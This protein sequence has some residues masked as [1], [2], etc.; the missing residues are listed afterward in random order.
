MNNKTVLA[1]L[2]LCSCGGAH[3]L[4][5]T[6]SIVTGL[7]KVALSGENAPGAGRTFNRNFGSPVINNLG[8]TAFA[9]ALNCCSISGG[10]WS[11][12]TGSLQNVGLTGSPAQPG[13]SQI[14]SAIGNVQLDDLGRTTVVA[15]IT[16]VP[17]EFRGAFTATDST[18]VTKIAASG[19]PI[20]GSNPSLNFVGVGG[21]VGSS[22]VI[23]GTAAKPNSSVT[24]LLWVS[25]GN[26]PAHKLLQS[27]D[28]VPFAG[29]NTVFGSQV[30]NTFFTPDIN[31]VGQLGLRASFVTSSSD[32]NYNYHLILADT[33]GN[34]ESVLD[35]GDAAPGFAAGVKFGAISDPTINNLGDFAYGGVIGPFGVGSREGVWISKHGAVPELIALQN[36]QPAA[37]PSL[38]LTKTFFDDTGDNFVRISDKRDVAFIGE[39]NGPGLFNAESVWIGS[40]ASNVHPLL[41]EGSA[42]PERPSVAFRSM[43]STTGDLIS[44]LTMNKNSQVAFLAGISGVGPDLR[45]GLFA[46]DAAGVLHP[47]VLYGDMIEVSPGNFR[48]VDDINFDGGRFSPVSGLNDL[49]QIAFAIRFTDGSGGVF[50]SDAVAVP[51][52]SLAAMVTAGIS[53]LA[54]RARHRSTRNEGA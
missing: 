52:P 3:C 31:G 40:S 13:G 41:I 26:G 51:E 54:I 39:V 18:H 43:P 33:N 37:A 21:V 2:L 29:P 17:A 45:S 24:S 8:Q 49:G 16:G 1:F 19:D 23:S 28:P 35:S 32:V 48:Q 11:T 22:G 4:A 10:V 36:T 34:L 12:G 38:T 9:G 15:Q 6:P 47:I 27:G 20:V 7:Q 14:Y 5:L 42:V 46:T 25:D 30:R 50:I 53:I 44:Q